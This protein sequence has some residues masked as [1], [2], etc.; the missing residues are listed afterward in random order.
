MRER[1][2][3]VLHLL[4]CVENKSLTGRRKYIFRGSHFPKSFHCTSWGLQPFC[5]D[6]HAGVY[7]EVCTD[8]L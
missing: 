3:L 4:S 6:V 5:I 8:K 2:S 7:T 1:I